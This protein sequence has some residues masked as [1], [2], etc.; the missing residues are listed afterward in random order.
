MEN[1]DIVDG[2]VVESKEETPVQQLVDQ[3]II[4]VSAT[5][6]GYTVK[7]ETERLVKRLVQA[8]RNR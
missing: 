1:D 6:V 7:W 8:Y 4:L 3:L 5:V 2:E